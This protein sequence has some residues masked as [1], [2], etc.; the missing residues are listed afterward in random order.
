M[1]VVAFQ[2]QV[3]LWALVVVGCAVVGIFVA[4]T[5][6]VLKGRARVKPHFQNVGALGVAC[7]VVARLIQYL[8]HSYAAPRFDTA[9]FND[10]RRL[11]HE[12]HGAWVQFATVFV[13]EERHRNPPASLARDAPIGAVGNHVAQPRSAVFWIEVRFVNRVQSEFA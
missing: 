6:H 12:S 1:L 2:I 7:C 9:F 13:Q 8:V 5:Q 4:A 10:I 11:V 3:G